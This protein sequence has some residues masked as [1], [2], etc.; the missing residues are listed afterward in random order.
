MSAEPNRK[1]PYSSDMRWRI[2]WQKFGMDL[3][4][5]QIARNLSI[6]IGTVHNVLKLFEETGEVSPKKPEREDM[7]KIDNSGELF[8]LG[9]LL[10]NPSLYLGE[11]CQ[12]IDSTFGIQVTPSTVCRIIQRNGFTRKKVQQVAKQRSVEFR[13]RFF[14]EVQ[15]YRPEQF[16]WVDESGCDK[17]D[18]IRKFGYALRGEYPVFHRFLHRGQR[19]S[20]ITALSTDGIVANEITKGTVN[21]E[22]FLEFVH[23]SLI[24][25]MLPFDGE[26]P[27]SIVVMDNCS[28]HHVQ[29]VLDA[30]NQAGIVV[31]FLPPYSPDMNPVENV[32]SYV[33]YYLKQHD[34]ILQVVPDI[35][36]ILEEGI[37]S[38]NSNN[39]QQWISHCG[40]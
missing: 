12:R 2:I 5:R 20:I 6:S 38:I 15:H 29:P 4:Y 34:D 21:G 13:G 8:I 1:A 23:G 28:I 37:K 36:P 35:C 10:E 30:F 32:F 7:R 11:I 25:N 31:L 18:H 3:T 9:L 40:Y 24:P 17:R 26:N 19:I 33:K 39:A 27:C 14:A 16:V 22:T